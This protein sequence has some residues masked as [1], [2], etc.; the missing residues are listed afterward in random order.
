MRSLTRDITPF[1][2]APL[3]PIA[4]PGHVSDHHVFWDPQEEI[5]FAGD[6]FL[7]VKVRVAH[8]N[9]DP[10]GLV[11]SLRACAELRPRLM[12]CAHRGNVAEPAAVL[13]AKADWLEHTIGEVDRLFDAGWH[14][15]AIRRA[16]LGREEVTDYFSFGDYSRASLIKA[17]QGT[18][19]RAA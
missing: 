11:R 16:V 2:P 13:S 19:E 6:L 1:D 3:V 4:T 5:L 14:E 7:G 12:F 15:S 8:P 17:I 18:R 9:E 10:R